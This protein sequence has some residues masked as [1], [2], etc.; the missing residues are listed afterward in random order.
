MKNSGKPDN[1]IDKIVE[2]KINKRYEEICLVKQP[3]VKQPEKKVED[4]V[5][6]TI[7]KLGGNI[8]ISAFARIQIGTK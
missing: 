6:E 7:A 4:I 1:I 2:G 5:H 3:F 8:K